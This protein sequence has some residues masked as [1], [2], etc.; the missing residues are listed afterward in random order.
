MS[1]YDARGRTET[2]MGDGCKRNIQNVGDGRCERNVGRCEQWQPS[3]P[4]YRHPSI[5]LRLL[6]STTTTPTN[7]ARRPRI[8]ARSLFFILFLYP[9]KL[10][11][12]PP[13][14]TTLTVF[15][16]TARAHSARP[17][18]FPPTY[19]LLSVDS[20]H[21]LRR[22]QP[23]TLDTSTTWRRIPPWA[24]FPRP[25]SLTSSHALLLRPHGPCLR[26]ASLS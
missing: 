10:C 26:S 22:Q 24:S 4:P 13:A 19:Y 20:N 17:D 6:I 11:S 18:S 9:D 14:R 23:P 25:S 15:I 5:P 7:S 21:L 2:T 8:V 3:Q 1:K 12:P 16:L